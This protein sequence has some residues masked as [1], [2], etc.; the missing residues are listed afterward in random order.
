MLKISLKLLLIMVRIRF[1]FLN[2]LYLR[3][4]PKFQHFML[5]TDLN[6]SVT[7]AIIP[8]CILYAITLSFLR[9]GTAKGGEPDDEDTDYTITSGVLR[10]KHQE[11]SKVITIPVNTSKNVS[12]LNQFGRKAKK[13][14]KFS[15][16]ILEIREITVFLELS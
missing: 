11:T 14:W 1:F 10:F 13:M 4:L 2:Y 6:K 12:L 15:Q 7:A 9:D 8:T 3:S 5:Y 16:F